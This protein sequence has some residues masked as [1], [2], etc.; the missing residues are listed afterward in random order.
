MKRHT[1]LILTVGLL[2]AADA[3]RP[4]VKAELE[5]LQGAWQLVSVERDGMTVPEES[6]QG[7]T[8]LLQRDRLTVFKGGKVLVR[9]TMTFDPTT[10]PATFVQT[11]A[12]GPA[13][14]QKF[15]GIYEVD[16][17]T[18]RSCGSSIDRERPRHFVTRDGECLFV[19][20][21]LKP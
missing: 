4:A 11:I 19:S 21:R 5:K 10:R 8:F 7:E 1:I 12:E 3:P 17:D 18:L 16:G 9:S 20:K 6:I 14:G 15:H 2:L 13:K